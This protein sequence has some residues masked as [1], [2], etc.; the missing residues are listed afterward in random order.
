MA[1]TLLRSTALCVALVAISVAALAE[2]PKEKEW[3]ARITPYLWL[4]AVDGD[5][6]YNGQSDDISLSIQDVLSSFGGAVFVNGAFEWR[7][8]LLLGDFIWARLTDDATSQTVSV[9]P[10]PIVRRRRAGRRGELR[11]SC[12]DDHDGDA[13][14]LSAIVPATRQGAGRRRPVCRAAR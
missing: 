4:P 2:A 14:R 13:P 12:A 6:S 8:F 9:G 1:V 5:M 10:G 7:R 11:M 3:S